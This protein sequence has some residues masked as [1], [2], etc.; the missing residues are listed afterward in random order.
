[1]RWRVIRKRLIRLWVVIRLLMVPVLCVLP[2]AAAANVVPVAALIEERALAEMGELMPDNGRI[3][4]RLA[5]GALDEGTFVQE[6]WLDPKSGQ[7]IANVVSS[8]G[9]THRVWGMALITVS[10]PVPTRRLLPDEIVQDADLTLIEL[11]V[12][13]LGAFAIRDSEELLGQQVRRMLQAGHPVPRQSVIPPVIIERGDKVKIVLEHGGLSLTTTG[14][15]MADAHLG[16]SLRVVNLSSNK[17]ITATAAASG[18]VE[19]SQ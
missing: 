14:R 18:I 5:Q 11:P 2:A 10:V 8:Y 19:V 17:T 13:R 3:E 15:A 4:I 1:M 16:Q 7:F 6:F 9:E 12:Q